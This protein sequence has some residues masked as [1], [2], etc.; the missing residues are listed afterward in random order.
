MVA[1]TGPKYL[2]YNSRIRILNNNLNNIV[3]ELKVD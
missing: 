2:E 3:S 1:L